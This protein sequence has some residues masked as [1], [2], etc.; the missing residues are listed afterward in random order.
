MTFERKA[1]YD[2]PF[3]SD[4]LLKDD[5]VVDLSL[6][7][8]PKKVDLITQGLALL[9]R[10]GR[11]FATTG[12]VFFQ[13]DAALPTEL[14]SMQAS[15]AKDAT[16]FLVGAQKDSPDLGVRI[17]VEI[18]FRADGGPFGSPNLLSL[19]PLQGRPLLPNTRYAAVVTRKVKDVNGKE[20][21]QSL[22]LAKLLAGFKPAGMSDRAFETYRAAISA[23]SLAANDLAGLAVFTTGDP[24][25]DF[26]KVV[27]DV[28]AR[29]TPV[30]TP[31]TLTD[32]FT[33]YCVFSSTVKLPVYQAGDPPYSTTG[34]RWVFDKNG[35]PK[36]QN[37]A[38]SRLV[39]TVPRTTT[40]PASG[41]RAAVFIR[42]GGGAD[43]PM[44]DRGPHPT[45][46]GT[47]P[48]GSGP[49]LQFAQAGF[50]GV[51]IDGPHGGP[52]NVTGGDEQVL[53]FNFLNAAALRDNVRQSALEI[54]LLSR[55]IAAMTFDASACP[56]APAQAKFDGT[57]M[58]LMGH[59]MGATIA[60]LVLAMEP[61]YGAAALSGSGASWIENVIYKIKPLEVRP[62][63]ETIIG[64]ATENRTLVAEDPVLTLVQWAAEPA[65]SAVY[66]RRIIQAPLTGESPRHVLMYQGLVDHYILPRIANAMSLS[67]GLDL[68]G[69]PQDARE[70]TKLPLQTPL[71]EV[72]GLVGRGKIALPASANLAGGTTGV[73]LQFQE[74][75]IEDGHEIAYQ[76]PVAR[77]A[78]RCF[79][80]SFRAGTPRIPVNGTGTDCSQ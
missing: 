44:V 41:F 54:V 18:R 32:T 45:A 40:M 4:D 46:W 37:E 63:A 33:D 74:D 73:V 71:T 5:G 50:A 70:Q 76:S 67:L 56:G 62:V 34:G 11:G 16:L 14:P 49:A 47:P 6:F 66:A 20:L 28:M 69:D 75:G 19:L 31:F 27:K 12:G 2:A 15:V 60:P 77:R 59:S 24:L 10:D 51:Q 57:K 23:L 36:V 65:D 61:R 22:E 42:T 25:A 43:R 29:P 21:G 26:E 1:L 38:T 39:V 48:G 58:G 35:V 68:A 30:P 64:Y 7:P 53:M 3:P 80:E 17:P 52:R 79:L 8:N 13:L 55:I 78:L 9:A 72:I